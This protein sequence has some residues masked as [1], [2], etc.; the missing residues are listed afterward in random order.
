MKRLSILLLCLLLI[1]P[2]G[3][4]RPAMAN[5]ADTPVFS[6]L[7]LRTEQELAKDLPWRQVQLIG[8]H[9]AYNDRG[10][11]LWQS[12]FWSL[13]EQLD[14]GV[15]VL[16]LDLHTQL[17]PLGTW[18]IKVCHGMSPQDCLF[19]GAGSRDYLEVLQE[20]RFW[21][22]RHPDQLVILELENHVDAAEQVLLPLQELFGEWIYRAAERDADWLQ[23]TPR[24]MLARGKRL[25]VA[26]FG[27]LRFDG[28]LIWDQTR[29]FSNLPSKAFKPGCKV[30]DRAMSSGNW[31][32]YDDK[33]IG[34]NGLPPINQRT[35]QTY[36][37]CDAR[38]LKIDRLDE[39]TLAAA[40]F[41]WSHDF[42][43]QREACASLGPAGFRWE[44]ANCRTPARSACRERSQPRNWRITPSEQSWSQSQT[45]CRA[46]FGPGYD[47]DTP[48]SFRQ[49]LDLWQ[50]FKSRRQSGP[51]L[52][53]YRLTPGET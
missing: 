29:W 3:R 53:N 22:G 6:W 16:E 23:E 15:R 9:N 51:I 21:V 39:A 52:L 42:R 37:A 24:Q 40:Q 26:D 11:P 28:K 33:T 17:S 49:N 27:P 46:A 2:L 47:F 7:A 45:A 48:R 34:F 8:A 4:L 31:G 36:L 35:I 41:S 14:H 12:Q 43:P 18:Q 25:I 5:Q 44:P 19:N 38:Y 1:L 13:T 50:A 30:G 10:D 32:F 20:I